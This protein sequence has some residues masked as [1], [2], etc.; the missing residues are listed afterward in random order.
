MEI[1][2]FEARPD[3]RIVEVEQLLPIDA[4]QTNSPEEWRHLPHYSLNQGRSMALKVIRRGDPEPEPNQLTLHRKLWLDF[5]GEGYTV[6]DKISGKMSKD[7]RLDVRPEMQLGKAALNGNNQL[8]TF[9]ETTGR[10]GVEVRQGAVGLDADSRRLGN[11]GELSA[12]GWEQSFNQVNAELNLPPGWRLLAVSGVDN[13]PDS[14]VFRWTL[15]DLFL[16]LI[17]ALA[18]SRLFG[19]NW[20]IFTLLTLAL[21]WHESGAPQ[22]IWLNILAV[23]A[24][25]R[26]LPSGRFLRAATWYRNIS[27]LLL[28]I[29]LV[30]FMADQ[31]RTGIYPQLEY[32]WREAVPSYEQ[33]QSG[34]AEGDTTPAAAPAALPAQDMAEPMIAPEESKAYSR[35]NSYD[36]PDAIYGK[37]KRAESG[38]SFNRYDPDAKVQTGPGL[39]QWQWR[40]VQLAWNGSVDANQQLRLWYLP[41]KVVMLLNFLRVILV[42]GLALLMFGLQNKLKLKAN[43]LIQA[44]V[45]FL[46]LPLINLPG[47]K[48]YADIPTKEVLEELKTRLLKAPDCLTNCAQIPSLAVVIG[49][50]ELE[51]NLQVHAQQEVNIPLPAFYGQWFPNQVELD[52]KTAQG[53]YRNGNELWVNIPAGQHA[54][55]MRGLSPLLPSFTLPLALKPNRI[56]SETG[57][58][59]ISGVQDD[60]QIES[61]LQFTRISESKQSAENNRLSPGALP[62]YVRVQRTVQLGLDWRVS[63]SVERLSPPDAAIVLQI[64]LLK[65]EKVTTPGIAVKDQKVEVNLPAQQNIFSWESNLDKTGTI[66][67]TAGINSGWQ[68][69]WKA[70]VSPIWHIETEGIPMIRLNHQGQ[71]LPEWHPWPGESMSLKITRPKPVEGQTL[72]IDSSRLSIRP[73]KRTRDADLKI[74]LR[75]SQGAQHTITLPENAVLQSLTINGQ[76]SP[77]RQEKN[78]LTIPV[79]PGSQEIAMTWQ[80]PAGISLITET[81]A[82]DLGQAS[83]NTRLGIGLGQD[84]WVLFT[85]GPRLGPAVLFW[86]VVIVILI[87]SYGLARIPLTPLKFRQW[88]LLLLGLSQLPLEAAGLVAA[89]LLLLGWRVQKPIG[90]YRY[91]NLFQL[92]LGVLTFISLAILITA[93]EQG[94]LGGSPNMQIIGNQSTAFD[95]NWYQDRSAAT[96]PKAMAVSIPVWMYRIAMLL[97]SFWLA[98]S[99]LNWLKWGWQSYSLGG[100]W[101]KKPSEIITLNMSKEENK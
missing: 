21:I 61:Q 23:L 38:D 54:V 78:R 74:S 5:D 65:G 82:V 60:G 15:L 66:E 80:E 96:L 40:R 50:K 64:P 57:G 85:W 69:V 95:L 100:F 24:L 55:V 13:L 75:S 31:V 77:V 49:E 2:A 92:L 70:D 16:V 89:W 35:G 72:T 34:L 83:I 1:W 39:P 99:L 71:W 6:N 14:W 11:T 22:Y 98:A 17:A 101:H 18:T 20:G 68:E 29:S 84:R 59:Q 42:C 94:L 88:F 93:V 45:L 10:Q 27:W 48:A 26:V 19:R 46:V 8:I 28:I 86:G 7:W 97:W 87:L 47:Q 52:G 25:I 30:P 33:P 53:L 76:I 91:F 12:A 62:P 73:G 90:H 67:L 41:P 58:W 81:P 4:S 9:N 36:K 3:L 44:L 37:L 56:T 32:P 43:N 51:I 63:T 79:N